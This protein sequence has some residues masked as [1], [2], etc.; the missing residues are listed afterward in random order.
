[1]AD[2]T[3]NEVL[4]QVAHPLRL[5]LIG[6]WAERIARAFWPLSSIILAFSAFLI[7]GLQDLAPLEAVW[8][9]VGLSSVSAVAAAIMGARRFHRPTLADAM[10]RLDS[11]MPGRPLA[12][13]TDHQ[14]IGAGDPASL[15]VWKA[16]LHRMARQA[17]GAKAV[18]P[19]LKLASRDPFALRYVALTA[20]VVALMFGSLWRVTSVSALA[21]GGPDALAA[22]PTWEGWAQ[23]PSYTGKP[24]IYLN[25]IMAESLDLPVGT[26]FQFRL[27]GEVGALTLSETVSGTTPDPT[28]SQSVARE[29]PLTL[30]GKVTVEGPGGR[31]W[32]FS[33]LPDGL[34]AIEASGD[35]GREA[36]GRF[37]QPFSARDDYG[38]VAGH[39]TIALDL[40]AADRRHG[41]AVDPEPQ[42]PVVL[43][44]P[45]P[46]TANRGEFTDILVD[47][48][49]KHVFA[50]LPVTMTFAAVDAAGQE[51]QS[52]PLSVVLPGRRFFDPLAAALIEL[53]RDVLWSRQNAPRAA[54][55]LKAVAYRPEEF[56]RNER[57][58]LRL[59]VVTRQLDEAAASLTAEK[60]DE[61]AE[62][63]WQIALLVEEGDLAS[64]FER[65][66]RAQDRLDEAIRNGASPEE[67]D[68]LMQEM[69]QALNDYMRELAEEA[70]RNPDSQMSQNMDGMQMSGDQ[71]QEMLEE[72]QKLMEEGRMAEA[73]ELM[74]LLRQ[75]MENMQVVQGQ[76]GQGQGQGNQ[77][78]RDLGETLRDQQELSDDAYRGMQQGPQ[79]QQGQG[80]QGNQG[81][82]QQPN[83]DDLAQRQGELRDRLGDLGRGT[84]PGEGT[85]QGD[86]A[87]RELDRAG[88]AMREAE[89]ALR[90]G[91]LPGA[92]DRQA[93]AIEAL[94]EGMRNLGEAMAEEQRQQGDGS[95]GAQVGRADPNSQRDPLGREPG[96]SARIG[97]DR[98]MLQGEDV[99]RRAQ[100][101]L[102]EI[103]RRTGDQSRPESERDY[104]KRLLDMF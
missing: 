54:Q 53:R 75:M 17:A 72:L 21:P 87:R 34:P 4:K 80:Q 64:A 84:L 52:E 76:G 97:S 92:L 32:F 55:I 63:L 1:M 13:L 39:V 9:V 19:D 57:A 47:D 90:D 88:R 98:N 41:L 49:S 99:Y 37:K 83:G 77:A 18:E 89:D 42:A 81:E 3:K 78:M 15:A 36:D 60:R 2:D 102:D 68:E 59:R 27:Y 51:G 11:R 70:E 82:G 69:R 8:A 16:H 12:A 79:G 96:D 62:E 40:A 104:L 58:Y 20:F 28:A 5:T 25:D 95:Q 71:L 103:R 67:I 74:E 33:A 61:V 43:D 56:I 86:N 26:R 100:D 101:L 38:V 31:S 10:V 30:S 7:F 29:F 23:P 24:T 65:L 44:L 94:R 48:L 93:E 73:Q 46:V 66:Q 85:E 45:L 35:M 14:V 22:G 91:D 50:N 6:L